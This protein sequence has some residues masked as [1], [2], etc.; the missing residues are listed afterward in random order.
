MNGNHLAGVGNQFRGTFLEFSKIWN[1][2][3]TVS[4]TGTARNSPFLARRADFGVLFSFISCRC[5]CVCVCAGVCVCACLC[6]C[7]CVC[8]GVCVCACACLCACICV[9]VFLDGMEGEGGRR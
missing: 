9:C 2:L 1:I 3:G 4:I 6:A 8:T 7:I 5:V